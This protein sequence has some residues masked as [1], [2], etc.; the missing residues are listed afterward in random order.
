MRKARAR[1]ARGLS[2]ALD[3]AHAKADAEPKE[4]TLEN[5]I[6]AG[7]IATIV[8]VASAVVATIASAGGE[9]GRISVKFENDRVRVLELRLKPG[10]SEGMHTHP[11]YVLYALTDYRVKN[12]SA[13]GTVRVF[14]RKRGDV[15]WGKPVTHGGENVGDTEVHALIVELKQAKSEQGTPI[16]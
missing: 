10:E 3:G 5:S 2:R 7:V 16:Q 8:I 14:D 9:G 12:T 11:D 1:P 6:W 15:F 4:G 13:D